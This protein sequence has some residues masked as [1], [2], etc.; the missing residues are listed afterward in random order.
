MVRICSNQD[1]RDYTRLP[2]QTATKVVSVDVR[3][4]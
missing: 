3:S 2:T 1:D 4:T